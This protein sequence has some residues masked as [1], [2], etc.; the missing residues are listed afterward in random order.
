MDENSA[1]SQSQ[2]VPSAPVE[3]PQ[4]S[5]FGDHGLL[6]SQG[7]RAEHGCDQ[8]RGDFADRTPVRPVVAVL[9]KPGG[10]GV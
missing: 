2:P 8:Q 6:G 3:E 1:Q 5:G 7:R 10:A 4:D 9:M